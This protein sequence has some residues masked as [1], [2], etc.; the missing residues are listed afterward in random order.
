MRVSAGFASLCLLLFAGVTPAQQ[1]VLANPLTVDRGEEVVEVPLAD[2]LAHTHLSEAQATSLVAT[3][4][5]TSVG[6]PAQL[7][8][9]EAGSPPDKLLLLV[10]V[11]AHGKLA[12]RFHVEAHPRPVSP[13]V[14]GRDAPERKDDFAWEN[15]LVAYRIY[16]PALEATGEIASGIDVWSKR[17]PDLVI[18]SFYKR[19]AE[20][21]RTHNPEL[22]YHKDNGQGLDSYYVGPTRGC[23]GTAVFAD[24]KLH[25]SKNYTSLRM[26]ADGPIRFAFEVSYAPWSAAGVQVTETKRIALDAGTH[27]NRITSTYNYQGAA[28]LDVVAGIAIHQGATAAFPERDK[29]AGV[30]DTPQDPTAGR[31]A[32]G[33]IAAP[34]QDA[35]TK[36][37]ADHAL[38]VFS[39]SSGQPFTY[40]AGSGWSKAD[41][42]TEAVWEDYLKLRLLLLE[43]PLHLHWSTH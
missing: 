12:V 33:L 23:G 22:S 1:L 34:G 11:Q 8:S 28:R 21:T 18:D 2:V 26:L 39:R 14:F 24:G 9:D 27:L 17:V 7:Y 15:Q 40:Y 42:P 4:S 36:R 19:D 25:A 43:H 29:V 31:I 32:T 37:A 3:D 10:H 38:L 5:L 20:G 30:W 35:H 6:I 41:M 13:L 16:G